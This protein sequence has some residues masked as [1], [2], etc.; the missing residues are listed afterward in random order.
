MAAITVKIPDELVDQVAL[1]RDHLPKLVAL[2]LHQPALPAATYCYILDFL[3]SK[4]SSEQTAAFRPTPEMQ[5]RLHT[6]LERSRPGELSTGDIRELDEY[7]RIEH[8]M[9]MIKAGNCSYLMLAA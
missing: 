6:L 5:T 3:T 4:S 9:V 1:L 2:S 7:A 8:C